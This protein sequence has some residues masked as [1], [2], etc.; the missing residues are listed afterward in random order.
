[1]RAVAIVVLGL[2]FVA[3]NAAGAEGLKIE[4]GKWEIRSVSTLPMQPEPRTRVSTECI[5]EAELRPDRLI[6]DTEGCQ[7]S[8]VVV[9]P[10][11][12]TWKLACSPEGGTMTGD[13]EIRSTGS[14]LD[15]SMQMTM[16]FGDRT[17]S[18][19][20]SWSGK[21]IGACD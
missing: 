10:G 8:D 6:D 20:H 2:G 7:T 19:Q 5:R 17:M 4:P 16:A 3:A 15:G 21:R 1:V 11:R 18:M 13:G 12:M 9:E 14:T